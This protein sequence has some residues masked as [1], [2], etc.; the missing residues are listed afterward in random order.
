MRVHLLKL[1]LFLLLTLFG[2][3]WTVDSFYA[4]FQQNKDGRA[5]EILMSNYQPLLQY[6]ANLAKFNDFDETN[7][8]QDNIT[9]VSKGAL[10]WPTDLLQRLNEGELVSLTDSTGQVSYYLGIE[11]AER[12]VMLTLHRDEVASE[13][14]AI[15]WIL[16]FY[17]NLGLV[18]WLWVYPLVKDVYCL[19]RAAIRFG[20]GKHYGSIQ[21]RNNSMLL[22]IEKAFNE[23]SVRIGNLLGLQQDINCA[24]SH[25]IRTPLSRIKFALAACD[26]VNFNQTK[27]SIIEDINEIDDLVNEILMYSKI[28]HAVPLLEI[29]RQHVGD[30]VVNVV[31]KY[32]QMTNIQ[33]VLSVETL[34]EAHFDS[35]TFKRAFQNLI[36]NAIR[37][38]RKT[39]HIEFKFVDGNNMLTIED[40]G[41]GIP[42]NMLMRVTQPF[43]STSNQER[44]SE[45][46]GLGLFI[47]KKICLWHNGQF[48]VDNTSRYGGARFVICWP[49]Q[50]KDGF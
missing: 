30:A 31:D 26:G 3:A 29:R 46:F 44:V 47:V 41:P 2:T 16:L 1:Y 34:T 17:G 15:F 4:Y 9:Y 20:Q 24:V 21:L 23:M 42:E 8:P 28:E 10:S 43:V 27:D 14:S 22:P 38:A 40:D 5:A 7:V 11:G 33:F 45:G 50:D 19:Q 32:R 25:D 6:Y 48:N 35:R 39:I 18:V 13:Q 37:F 36:D 12:V 49:N